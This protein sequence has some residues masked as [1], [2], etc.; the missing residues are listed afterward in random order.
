[1]TENS[2]VATKPT[3]QKEVAS[4]LKQKKKLERYRYVEKE[5]LESSLISSYARGRTRSDSQTE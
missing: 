3:M 4:P 5:E 1:M 2:K